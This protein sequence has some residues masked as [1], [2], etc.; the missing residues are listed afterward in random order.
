MLDLGRVYEELNQLEHARSA[1]HFV[2]D[3]NARGANLY[4]VA[5]ARQNALAA[6]IRLLLK[7]Q[8]RLL[9]AQF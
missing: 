8:S 4:S 6:L 3:A 1:F 5:K 2:L 7:P 9:A